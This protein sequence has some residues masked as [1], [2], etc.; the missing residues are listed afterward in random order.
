VS[1]HL[2]EQ[3]LTRRR[4]GLLVPRYLGGDE[5]VPAHHIGA[6]PV[7]PAFARSFNPDLDELRH[8]AAKHGM[9]ASKQC[10]KETVAWQRASGTLLTNYTTA[11][12]VVNADALWD[13]PRNFLDAGKQIE[14]IVSGAISNIVTTP[15]TMNFQLKIGSVAAFDTGAMQLN[16]TAHTTRRSC[17]ISC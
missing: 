14:V 13:M 5:L 3:Q 4:S 16:A 11:K 9:R 7:D 6:P 12:S 8:I 10:W 17:S 1:R 15:G 2:A